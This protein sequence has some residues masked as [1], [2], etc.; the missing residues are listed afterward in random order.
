MPSRYFTLEEANR[1]LPLVRRI[2]ADI[3]ALHPTW[4]DLVY[5][6]EL[7]AAEARPEWGE[8]TES[9][10]LRAQI[11]D[12]ARRIQDYVQELEQIGCEFKGFA[13]GLVDFHGTLDGREILW[14]WKQ[15]EERIE[16]WH[17]AESGFAGR[18]PIPA[19]LTGGSETP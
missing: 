15:G 5:R 19:V 1:T 18:Q 17:D 16:H 8:S 7:A 9:M 6:F 3:T 14:C 2:V 10:A 12:I 13:E 11:E 4:R